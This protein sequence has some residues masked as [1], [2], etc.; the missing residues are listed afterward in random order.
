MPYLHSA[1]WRPSLLAL[2]IFSTLPGAAFAAA[3]E[4]TVTATGNAR[5]TFEAPMMVSVI[6]ATAPE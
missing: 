4:M 5:S 1:S 6:D 2:A 3:E